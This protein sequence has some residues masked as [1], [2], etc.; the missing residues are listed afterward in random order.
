MTDRL[1]LPNPQY[2]RIPIPV[3]HQ[4]S[5]EVKPDPGIREILELNAQI[6]GPDKFNIQ[7]EAVCTCY[8]IEKSGE[9]KK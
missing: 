4:K 1:A 5:K 7:E 6:T 8:H 3:F 9:K 2:F